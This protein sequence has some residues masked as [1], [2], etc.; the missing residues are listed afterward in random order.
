MRDMV[1][2]FWQILNIS[3]TVDTYSFTFLDIIFTTALLGCVGLFIGKII[4][5]ILNDR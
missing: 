3:F 5:F 4:F 2:A 1:N